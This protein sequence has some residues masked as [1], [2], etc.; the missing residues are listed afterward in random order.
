M[1]QG[2]ALGITVGSQY[3]VA[4]TTSRTYGDASDVAQAEKELAQLRY[5]R[6]K[7][8]EGLSGNTATVVRVRLPRRPGA[9]ATGQV[10]GGTAQ[11]IAHTGG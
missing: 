10:T 11:V 3:P 4:A 9:D 8:K 5:Y 2:L 1:T 7:A 6:R